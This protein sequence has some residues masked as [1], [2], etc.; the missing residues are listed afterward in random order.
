MSKKL[1]LTIITILFALISI[2]TV[3]SIIFQ[4]PIATN[5]ID[6]TKLKV[7][8]IFL[9]CFVEASFIE[10][11]A[12]RIIGGYLFPIILLIGVLF[13]ILHWPFGKEMIIISG[14]AILINLTL[15]SIKEKNKELINY[16]L[17]SF[18][19]LRL[20]IFLTKYNEI[21]WWFDIAVSL[22]ITIIGI[23]K[24]TLKEK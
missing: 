16:L 17:F 6:A 19:C 23:K 22:I 20:I 5:Y 8:L 14:L 12:S 18:V 21:L 3:L 2:Q 24:L 13:R 7:I 11:K 15:S 9:I 10:K 4:Q 1:Y